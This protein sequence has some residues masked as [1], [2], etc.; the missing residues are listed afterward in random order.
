MPDKNL[1]IVG[2]KNFNF[3]EIEDKANGEKY[4]QFEGYLSTF[5]NIDLVDDVCVQ[6]C[7][8]DSLKERTPKLLFQHNWDEPV[9]IFTEIYEDEKGLY[10]KGKMPMSDTT[11][12]GKIAPQ[13]KIGSIDS[14]SIGYSTEVYEINRET[15]IRY[16]KKVK[17][18][19]GSIVTLPANPQA[20]IDYVK[21]LRKEYTKNNKIFVADFPI[22]DVSEKWDAEKASERVKNLENIPDL[23]VFDCVEGKVFVNPRACFALKAGIIGAKGG[24]KGDVE[25]AK[26]FLNEYYEKMG[27]DAPFKEGREISFCETEFKNIPLAEMSFILRNGKLSKSC[28]DYLARKALITETPDESGQD[29]GE[30]LKEFNERLEKE[31]K[32]ITN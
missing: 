10:V 29:W 26:S 20:R 27:L 32:G 12:S 3:S 23:P 17:L 22:L 16:L 28:S 5:G 6:G 31:I 2:M 11:V 7:F 15:G 21:N 8:A 19:E 13:M 4:F 24:F 25:L 30:A 14:M 1:M 18:W 9:G